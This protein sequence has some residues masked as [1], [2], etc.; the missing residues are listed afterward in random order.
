[1]ARELAEL[2]AQRLLEEVRA[3]GYDGGYGRVRAFVATLRRTLKA[4]VTRFETPPLRQGPVDSRTFRTP[5][6]PRYALVLVLGYSGLRCVSLI[7]AV[8]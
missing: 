1:M 3:A 4:P 6:G 8:L 7:V 5:W 2:A